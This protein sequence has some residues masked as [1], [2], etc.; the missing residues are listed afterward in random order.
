MPGD[1]HSMSPDPACHAWPVDIPNTRTRNRRQPPDDKPGGPLQP[2]SLERSLPMSAPNTPHYS[3]SKEAGTAR[4]DNASQRSL[5]FGPNF[6]LHRSMNHASEQPTALRTYGALTRHK[7]TC[8]ASSSVRT[9]ADSNKAFTGDT[10]TGSSTLTPHSALSACL[11]RRSSIA[12]TNL[13]IAHGLSI[14]P[15]ILD[16]DD[17]ESVDSDERSSASLMSESEDGDGDGDY[18]DDVSL[19]Q[20]K[21]R[22]R[23]LPSGNTMPRN[24]A[25]VR[26]QSLVEEEK[27]AL[28]SEMEHES[29]ITRSIRHNNVQEWLRSSPAND[30]PASRDCI[31]FPTSPAYSSSSVVSSP[32]MASLSTGSPAAARPLKRKSVD[33]GH[34]YKRQAMSPLGLRAQI[35]MGR[36]GGSLMLPHSP[37]SSRSSPSSP[38]LVAR[39]VAV[40]VSHLPAAQLQ[41][42][43]PFST[44]GTCPQVSGNLLFHGASAA[45]T[46]AGAGLSPGFLGSR[47]RSR[48]GTSMAVLGASNMSFLQPNGGFSRMNISD[49]MDDDEP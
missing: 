41:P 37:S 49:P 35:A 38:Q 39:P 9:A 46:P 27:Q 29:Q 24:R 10:P 11:A 40:P 31:P 47:G 22:R 19:G 20:R 45:P 15:D 21:R 36:R 2:S 43:G 6:H 14:D 23:P 44:A 8:S 12:I 5:A 18:G 16:R 13:S 48:S 17:D 26:L 4:P 1:S 34:P 32:R 3:H 7:R 33:D 28:A 42:A 25:V 30:A